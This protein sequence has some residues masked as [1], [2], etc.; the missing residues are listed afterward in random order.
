MYIYIYVYVFFLCL[1]IWLVHQVLVSGLRFAAFEFGTNTCR[2]V[3]V[4]VLQGAAC[5]A[6]KGDF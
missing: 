4:S 6:S 1:C 5:N 3:A 2:A